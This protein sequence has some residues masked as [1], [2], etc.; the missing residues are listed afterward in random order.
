M[1]FKPEEFGLQPRE[2][3]NENAIPFLEGRPERYT[4]ISEAEIKD[5]IIILNDTTMTW[6][7]FI[8]IC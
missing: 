3:H 6:D 7:K 5:L 8:S 1:E 4:P 2:S